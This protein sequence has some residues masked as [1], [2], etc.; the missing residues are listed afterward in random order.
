MYPD[1][2][3]ALMKELDVPCWIAGGYLLSCFTDEPWK[4]IDVF[5]SSKDIKQQAIDKM[6]Q[7]GYSSVSCYDGNVVHGGAVTFEYKGSMVDLMHN[8]VRPR[9]TIRGFDY[10]ICC[11]SLDHK[12]MLEYH[13]DYFNHIK[14]KRIVYTGACQYSDLCQRLWRLRS[15]ITKGYGLEQQGIIEWIDGAT[16]QHVEILRGW[17]K[18]RNEFETEQQPIKREIFDSSLYK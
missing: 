10:T 3:I 11:C 2:G 4:D 9:Q 12:G 8:G 5:F 15:Y 14:S 13:K 17:T 18:Y 6:I 1:D 7:L 16:Q